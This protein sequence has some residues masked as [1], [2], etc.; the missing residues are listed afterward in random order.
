VAQLVVGLPAAGLPLSAEWGTR[1][2]PLAQRLGLPRLTVA[3]VDELRA[4]DDPLPTALGLAAAATSS[5]AP[6]QCDP[7]RPPRLRLLRQL[8][9][10]AGQAHFAALR[11]LGLYCAGEPLLRWL[12]A[13][14]TAAL[15]RAA[16]ALWMP[17]LPMSSPRQEQLQQLL[18][19]PPPPRP[20]V[21][22][23]WPAQL[24]EPSAEPPADPH[25]VTPE[26]AAAVLSPC[27]LRLHAEPGMLEQLRPLLLE[28][29]HQRALAQALAGL[30]DVLAALRA[31]PLPAAAD[32]E[33]ARQSLTQG[34][35]GELVQLALR[36]YG[37]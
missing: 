4:V 20:E 37:S 3:L 22:A 27:L 23:T 33:A 29:M 7:T 6:A 17:G 16:A 35:R 34:T 13:A 24:P 32:A 36:L 2:L 28:R 25:G 8:T 9:A 26:Q 11:A 30:G 14:D 1:L 19:A 31:L 18:Q 21:P 12:D 10:D 15:L 5:P